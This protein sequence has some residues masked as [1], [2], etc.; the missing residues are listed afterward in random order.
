MDGIREAEKAA[1]KARLLTSAAKRESAALGND[2]GAEVA[3]VMRLAAA[4]EADA[5]EKAKIAS[6]ELKRLSES[7]KAKA[8][9]EEAAV[10]AKSEEAKLEEEERKAEE[11][12][13]LAEKEAEHEVHTANAT[14]N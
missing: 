2:G 5:A 7:R 6:E 8:A 12:V 1:E 9:A 4:A 13:A 3:E 14:S 10:E 11:A